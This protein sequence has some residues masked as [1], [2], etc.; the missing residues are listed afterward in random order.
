MAASADGYSIMVAGGFDSQQALS[1]CDIFE[2]RM[3]VRRSQHMVWRLADARQ[4]CLAQLCPLLQLN[5]GCQVTA[6]GS[7]CFCLSH[8]WPASAAYCLPSIQCR[9]IAAGCLWDQAHLRSSEPS[10]Q[11][12]PADIGCLAVQSWRKDVAPMSVERSYA[13]AALLGG[14]LYVVGGH[15]DPRPYSELVRSSSMQLSRNI[16]HKP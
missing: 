8:V 10:R 1:S 2:L 16:L 4:R 5:W 12:T 9:S 6:Q 11:E 14:G 3:E 13:C 15:S 7:V